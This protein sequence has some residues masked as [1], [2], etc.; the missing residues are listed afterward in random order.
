M[1]KNLPPGV[2]VYPIIFRDG[3]PF[4]AMAQ[5]HPEHKWGG[6][7]FSPGGA[8]D[9]GEQYWDA[10]IREFKEETGRDIPFA[11][12]MVLDVRNSS[13]PDGDAFVAIAYY[14]LM[15]DDVLANAEPHKQTDWQYIALDEAVNLQP[16]FKDIRNDL[17]QLQEVLNERQPK[18]Q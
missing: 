6:Y 13:T 16:M 5:K 18:L 11:R 9:G 14:T 10:A 7:W 3:R 1:N 17:K 15:P 4:V 12:L 8:V 2:G